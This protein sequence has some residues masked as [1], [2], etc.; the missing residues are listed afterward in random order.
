MQQVVN[1]CGRNI[2]L[3]SLPPGVDFRE[4][5]IPMDGGPPQVTYEG[6][7]LPGNSI[8]LR[9]CRREAR[10]K[11]KSIVDNYKLLNNVLARY[12]DLIRT[13]WSK[14]TRTQRKTIL[15]NSW[16]TTIPTS[17]RADLIAFRRSEL[18]VGGEERNEDSAYWWPHINEEDLLTPATIPRFLNSRGRNAPSVF[19]DM[20]WD[21]TAIG[22]ELSADLTEYGKLVK[23]PA[24]AEDEGIKISA[25]RGLL[26]LEIQKAVMEFLINVCQ[27]I[28]HEKDLD[29][30][31]LQQ[32][33]DLERIQSPIHA[34]LRE[35]E[36]YAWAMREDPSFFAVVVNDWSEH[37]SDQIPPDGKKISPNL[38]HPIRIRQ[39]W[40]RTVSSA[41]NEVYGYLV[42]W[43]LMSDKLDAII[44]L[45]KQQAKGNY[46]RPEDVP[47]LVDAVRILKVILDK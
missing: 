13:R 41:I 24:G 18:D 42:I 17:H 39:H 28:L 6:N 29:P 19:V 8:S 40:D 21:S 36:D 4:T 15:H 11:S 34:R 23:V 43:K 1:L 32:T 44:E 9:E 16:H 27:G 5:S 20:D 12:E 14:K 30:T 2:V 33:V 26:I 45:Q 46:G 25:T 10:A 35:R 31:A 22:R 7:G 37:S 38:S 47:G 3:E